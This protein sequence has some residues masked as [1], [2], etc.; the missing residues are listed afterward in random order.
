MPEQTYVLLFSEVLDKVHKEI[1]Y[2][3]RV[4]TEKITKFDDWSFKKDSTEKLYFSKISI[5]SFAS[6][7]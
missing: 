2:Q 1:P 6:L 7:I 4:I 5:I 3:C